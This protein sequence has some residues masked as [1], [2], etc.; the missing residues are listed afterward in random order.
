MLT[1]DEVRH[2]A[3]LARL[4]LS[5]QEVEAMRVQ[6][7]DILQYIEVLQQVDTSSVEPT[8]QVL[9]HLNVARNDVS[10]PSW[11]TDE[12]LSNAPG[13]EEGFVRVPTV[14]EEGRGADGAVESNI[15][16]ADANVEQDLG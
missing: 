4:G 11:P 14:L 1:H 5:E 2:V 10:R 9:T 3:M 15:E 12:I 7:L 16:D 6:L 13:R 8:A